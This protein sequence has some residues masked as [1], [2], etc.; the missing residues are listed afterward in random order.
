[1]G[2]RAVD[3]QRGADADAADHEPH[4][5]DEAVGQHPAQVVFDDREKDG[6][7]GHD[8]AD[9]DQ[10]LGP[11]KAPGQDIDGRFGGEGAQPDHPGDGGFRIG[12]GQPGV[13]QRP[14]AID[15]HPDKDQVG[16]QAV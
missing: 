13:Q 5:V 2:D 15:P 12:I 3:R 4:L 14:G 10:G 8:G 11:R 16:G 7:R 1:M 6:E 9:P